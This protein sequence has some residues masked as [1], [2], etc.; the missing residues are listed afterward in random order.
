[1]KIKNEKGITL[2]ALLITVI[3]LMII[4]GVT[5]SVSRNLVHTAKFENAETTLLLIQSK[6]KVMADKKA[7]G[8]IEEADLY[9]T[10]QEN[11]EYEGWYLLSNADLENMGIKD[12]DAADNYYVNYENDDVAIG[13]GIENNNDIYYK[14][15]NILGE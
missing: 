8:E 11:G 15:S 5:I 6:V 2:I 13:T 7:I 9:G 12:A 4:A 3:V 1:M 14:L 10:K